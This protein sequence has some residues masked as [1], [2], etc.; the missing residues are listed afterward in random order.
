[1]TSS[2]TNLVQPKLF[3]ETIQAAALDAKR[4]LREVTF[5]AQ[6]ADHPIIPGQENTQYLKFLVVQVI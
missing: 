1:V 4:R 5:N 2:C 6:S 3:L